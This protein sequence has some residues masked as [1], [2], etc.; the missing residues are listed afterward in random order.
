MDREFPDFFRAG[1]ERVQTALENLLPSAGA[2]RLAE[3]MRYS[4][5]GGGKR[6][7]GVLV[8]EAARLGT[9]YD[10]S[11]AEILG[12]V[13]EL[14]H[15]YTLVHDD[16]PAMDDDDVRRG[17]P[18]NHKKYDEATAILAGNALLTR[19]FEILGT[20]S[21][22]EKGRMD[23][24]DR[25]GEVLGWS[26]ILEGQQMDLDMEGSTTPEDKILEM[27]EKKTGYLLS[28]A[29]E[30]GAV[31]GGLP[32]DDRSTLRII[33]RT[34]GL[35][36]QVRDDLLEQEGDSERIGKDAKSDRSKAKSTLV[37]RLGP[38][39]ARDRAEDYVRK[40]QQLLD[41]LD[42]DTSRLEE[43][44]NFLLDRTY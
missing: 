37:D 7:R 32:E 34:L 10:E 8:L 6:I 11:L 35:A 29:L 22:E 41:D 1:R 24:L 25:T 2:N 28:L 20:A 30:Y 23:L 27:Y 18:A 42:Y 12:G 44:A 33:G 13:V 31:A 16:L 4:V 40:G 21:M 36:F 38:E 26:G 15:T 3:A 14:I 43:L 19:A 17:Q 9:N 5:L 39:D